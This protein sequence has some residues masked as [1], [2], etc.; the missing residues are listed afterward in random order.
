[1]VGPGP[2]Q[3]IG[4]ETR[5]QVSSPAAFWTRAVT[6]NE[7]GRGTYRGVADQGRV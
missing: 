4:L 7:G 5:A 1:M 2:R 3:G 6:K